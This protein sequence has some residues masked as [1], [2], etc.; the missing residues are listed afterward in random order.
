[1]APVQYVVP[2]CTRA[3]TYHYPTSGI[4][5]PVLFFSS[6]HSSQSCIVDIPCFNLSSS[7]PRCGEREDNDNNKLAGGDDDGYEVRRLNR[8]IAALL[9]RT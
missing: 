4:L 2:R 3:T 6:L 8:A 5:R 1:M 9:L 7:Y